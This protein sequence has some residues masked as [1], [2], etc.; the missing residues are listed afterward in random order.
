MFIQST[1][2]TSQF[3]KLGSQNTFYLENLR[4]INM[5]C[6]FLLTNECNFFVIGI[7]ISKT[8]LFGIFPVTQ[9]TEK[10]SFVLCRYFQF[11]H[12]FLFEI[13][14]SKKKKKKKRHIIR[15]LIGRYFALSL[16]VILAFS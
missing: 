6:F 14:Y 12:I 15:T 13:C 7:K 9:I 5:L 11:S 16:L 1:K 2:R 4:F 3:K 8:K 10:I